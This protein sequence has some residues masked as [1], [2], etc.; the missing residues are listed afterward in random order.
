MKVAVSIRLPDGLFIRSHALPLP[1]WA[2]DFIS[3]TKI[4]IETDLNGDPRVIYLA[5]VATIK[6]TR[7]VDSS[8]FISTRMGADR[9]S[10]GIADLLYDRKNTVPNKNLLIDKARRHC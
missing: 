2:G 4:S 8:A 10:D 6:R 1:G 5:H 3:A 7:L 9:L